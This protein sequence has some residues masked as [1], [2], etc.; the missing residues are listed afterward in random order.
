MSLWS[1]PRQGV[2]KQG[3][4]SPNPGLRHTPLVGTHEDV[5]NIAVETV[6]QAV[7]AALARAAVP[8]A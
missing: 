3:C 6:Q 4:P 2:L 5:R 7:D 8:A 1:D